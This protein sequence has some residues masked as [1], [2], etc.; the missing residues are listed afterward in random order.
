MQVEHQNSVQ[1]EDITVCRKNDE[2]HAGDVSELCAVLLQLHAGD[3]FYLCSS[4]TTTC[5]SAIFVCGCVQ[6]NR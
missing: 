1:F 5:R 6:V 3:V 4:T 2:V